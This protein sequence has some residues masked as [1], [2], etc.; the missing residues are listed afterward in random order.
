LAH[1]ASFHS[2]EKTAPSKSGIKH[3][4]V[5]LAL[6]RPAEFGLIAIEGR[7][8]APALPGEPERIEWGGR[9]GPLVPLTQGEYVYT[10]RRCHFASS[11]CAI[12]LS[13]IRLILGSGAFDRRTGHFDNGADKDRTC[14]ARITESPNRVDRR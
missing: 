14:D 1:S 5:G 4:G 11:F 6:R 9:V 13:M 8:T 2:R 3:L 10:V 7:R 12:F